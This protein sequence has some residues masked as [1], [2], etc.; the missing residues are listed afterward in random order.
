MH[1][2]AEKINR[3]ICEGAFLCSALICPHPRPTPPLL[4]P[5]C[6]GQGSSSSI[7]R[8]PSYPSAF[9]DP[10]VRAPHHPFPALFRPRQPLVT[11]HESHA[12]RG[13]AHQIYAW[14]YSSTH[15]AVYA[16]AIQK[17]VKRTP[18]TLTWA[19]VSF[20]LLC[21]TLFALIFVELLFSLHA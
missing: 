21:V 8:P 10:S 17:L 2:L 3:N 16:R 12:S 20:A 19:C 5:L 11:P 6:P 13:I 4:P 7:L 1:F 14:Q 15:S 9:Y 18:P